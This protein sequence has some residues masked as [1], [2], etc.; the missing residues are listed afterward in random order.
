MGLR[1]RASAG[2]EPGTTIGFYGNKRRRE[3]E[4]FELADPKH[5]SFKWME[6]IDWEPEEHGLIAPAGDYATF[7]P[8]EA[9]GAVVQP[10]S[11]AAQEAKLT[12]SQRQILRRSKKKAEA[13]GQVPVT[14]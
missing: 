13:A 3:G 2:H 10:S 9:P 4:E 1:V 5:F 14:E 8:T 6:P 7:I 11:K 12:R